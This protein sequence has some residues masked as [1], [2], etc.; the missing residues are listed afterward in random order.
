MT[1]IDTDNGFQPALI[2]VDMQEDFCPPNP[3]GVQ[4][5]RDLVPLINE[6]IQYPGFVVRVATQDFH[7]ATHIS[8]ASNHPAPN[9][10]PFESHIQMTNPAVVGSDPTATIAQRLWPA[11]CVQNTPGAEILPA[12]RMDK[13]DAVVK[14]G[15]DERVEMYSAF[16]DAFGNRDCKATGGASADLEAI[17]REKG[18][19]DVFV[20]GLAGDYCVKHT[21]IDAAERGFK[22]FVIE[23]GVKCVD[24]VS[25]WQEAKVELAARG[26]KV[27]GLD[28]LEVGRVKV[29]I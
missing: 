25:G 4:G 12:I 23:E 13:I 5:G 20:V 11:H 28:G 1:S 9:N 21:A 18:V 27:V 3:L 22:T 14:K 8:F 2:V 17:L 29:G 6:I 19:T 7:P 16:A 26:V 10:N 24:A 15:M